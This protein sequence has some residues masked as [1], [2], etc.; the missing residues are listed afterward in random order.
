MGSFGSLPK[1]LLRLLIASVW[2]IGKTFYAIIIDRELHKILSDKYG[3]E[4]NAAMRDDSSCSVSIR[5]RPRT[6]GA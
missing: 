2:R 5:A 6:D 3:T 1:A 4:Y